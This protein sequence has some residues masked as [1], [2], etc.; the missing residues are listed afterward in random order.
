[1][2]VCSTA[3][4]TFLHVGRRDKITMEA[5]PLGGYRARS[6]MTGSFTTSATA[7]P[8]CCATPILRNPRL[9]G[10]CRLAGDHGGRWLCSA[11]WV[12]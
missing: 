2:H 12:R 7:P 5:G 8:M 10:R 4:L 9:C 6:C 11:P 3:V 1:V